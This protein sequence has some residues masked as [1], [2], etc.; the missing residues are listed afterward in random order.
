MKHVM[1]L[2]FAG[3]A[4]AILCSAM[5]VQAA[6]Y[7]YCRAYARAAVQQF[8]QAEANPYCASHIGGPRWMPDYETHF[9]WCLSVAPYEAQHEWDSRSRLLYRCT[10]G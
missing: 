8:G 6:E 3:T 2:A 9:D 1:R 4:L 7:G 5:P 10:H